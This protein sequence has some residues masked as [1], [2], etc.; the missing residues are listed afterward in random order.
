MDTRITSTVIDRA[1]SRVPRREH[2]LLQQLLDAVAAQPEHEL[3]GDGRA[4]RDVLARADVTT[5][6]K[7]AA[8][9]LVHRARAA[10]DTGGPAAARASIDAALQ[11]LDATARQDVAVATTAPRAAPTFG[12]PPVLPEL[13]DGRFIQLAHETVLGRG[14]QPQEL[15][16]C[17]ARLS[18]GLQRES[19]LAALLQQAL[20]VAES[21]ALPRTG[22]PF[23]RI[24]GTGQRVTLAD[25]QA[26]SAELA[27]AGT[28]APPVPQPQR[29]R[30]LTPPRVRVSAITSLY[31]GGAHIE[32]FM[33]NMVGQS[34]FADH[35]ELIIVDANS[36]D[37]ERTVIERHARQHP[38]IRYLHVNHRIGVYDAWNIAVQM[39]RGDYLTTT[40][41]DDLRRRDSL[42]LQAAT[43]DN[44]PFVDVVY[45][46]FYYTFDP[47]LSFEQVAAHGLKSDL[48]L[49]TPHGLM[50]C[51]PP[52]NAPMWRRRLHDELGLFDTRYRS[53]G[54]YDFWMRCAAA[55]K[56][57]YK[58]NDAHV[59]Y[60]QNPQGIST[61]PGT[62]GFEEI[63]GVHKRHGRMV[64]S[65]NLVM[66][67]STFAAERLRLPACQAK[68]A[69]HCMLAYHALQACAAAVSLGT[70]P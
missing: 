22:E 31:A 20:Q 50:A 24:M 13:D 54:D 28:P 66:P 11:A 65:D 36:P 23:L 64:V 25:W 52:H 6:S 46:D 48:P 70:A 69:N 33:E 4:W 21:E 2:A 16:E 18:Q 41:V 45:Q 34:G 7:A 56:T 60:Y 14:C 47:D 57:F 49:V 55:G 62:R 3:R 40:N 30:I 67:A 15:L 37:G 26:R 35:V 10:A 38:N 68:E 43:L 27:A 58:A 17:Q 29:F 8:G 19:L 5:A 9:L 39:A 63:R 59:V 51:N 44:L 32:R 12:V 61:R 53:A 1:L 42:A